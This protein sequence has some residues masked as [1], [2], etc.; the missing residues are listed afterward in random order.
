[1]NK[2]IVKILFFL[3]LSV[4]LISTA[5]AQRQT[6]S[7][8]GRATDNEG[9]PL[10]GATVILSGPAL[11]GT[12]SYVT[13]ETGD[14]RFP[15]VPPGR[16]YVITAEMPGF[17]K[18]I[19]TDLIVNVGKTFRVDVILVPEA[20]E[21]EITVTARAPTVDVTSSKE[22]V[23]YSSELIENI[24][25]ERS[26]Y[27]IVEAAPGVVG[28]GDTPSVHGGSGI[29]S[30]VSVD[31]VNITDRSMGIQTVDFSFDI[32]EEVELELGAHPAEVGLTESGY[33]NVVT[34]SGGNEFHGSAIAYYYNEDM[35]R[36]VIPE[37]EIKAVGLSEPTGPTSSHDFSL[38]F[39]GPIFKDKLWFFING[40]LSG[41]NY[42]NETIVDGVYDVKRPAQWGF[43]KL[44]FMAHQNIKLTGMASLK[45]YDSHL[46]LVSYY[47]GKYT[48]NYQDNIKN[49]I[50]LAMANWIVNQNTFLDFR[51]QFINI[52]RPRR[53]HPDSDP[54]E[55]V[56][57]DRYTGTRTGPARWNDN[58]HRY[59][60]A[61]SVSFNHFLDNVLGGNHQIKA[62]IEW[63]TS[64]VDNPFWDKRAISQLYT[65]Q[66]LPWGYHDV[67]PYKGYFVH[68]YIGENE[69]D[70]TL[71]SKVDKWG[72]Y[73]QDSFTIKNRLTL[74]FGL[75]YNDIRGHNPGTDLR[76][77][78]MNSP[79]LTMLAPELF[80]E[81]TVPDYNDIVV[82]KS[83]S[84]R[85]GV[86]YDLFG[87]QTTSIKASWSRYYTYLVLEL[88]ISM[89]N[90][91]PF[92]RSVNAFWFDLNKNGVI[93]TSDSFQ[94]VYKPPDPLQLDLDELVDPNLK[95][96]YTDEFIVGIERE[97]FKDF[98]FGVSYIYKEAYRAIEDVEKYRG[99]KPDSEWWIPY[100]T[101]EPGPDGVFGN[102]DDNQIT[103]YGVKEGAPRSRKWVVNL[104]DVKRKYQGLELILNKRMSHGWQLYGSVVISKLE[105]TRDV[106]Y[107]PS[108]G[109]TAPY[110]TPNFGINRY[111]RLGHDRPIVIKLQSSVILPFGFMVSGNYFYSSGEP[112]AR[113]LQIQL[114]ND[115]A[116]F[117]YPGNFTETVNAEIPGTR[118]YRSRNN[119]DL[120]I[121][122]QFRI[123]D[124]GRLGLFVDVLNVFGE[125]FFTIGEDPGGRVYNDGTFIR[126]SQYGRHNDIYGTRT[127]KASVR[128]TF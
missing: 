14:F 82:W 20:L 83:L 53:L 68:N 64:Y 88:F 41:E 80:K 15:A 113:T 101:T 78:G 117:E 21:E 106:G 128:F 31:G 23:T 86:V 59:Q 91:A 72:G 79:V 58:F 39:G 87:D 99:Y 62:G 76:P 108:L 124:F 13:T 61:A 12:L 123:R 89:G 127:F 18:F 66:G 47:R 42:R 30:T 63:E 40:R 121:E 71:L 116:T 95:S 125:N 69:D 54:L 16:D 11:M 56:K 33:I 43:G 107:G 109:H 81:V 49:W 119:L 96:P 93:E 57:I 105:G 92:G 60:Y 45:M 85:V 111:G 1:M 44:T 74:N 67:Q 77:V 100:T 55:P 28:D 112:W 122:K 38:T 97:L 4:G 51:F 5:F 27:S 24:P 103:V 84:P 110:D 114:P 19:R 25:V 9:A 6:G 8:A 7:I 70:W 52:L 17:K 26:Y 48:S 32:L 118:R 73:L 98:R 104:E 29:M 102:A 120:R 36:N 34:K 22:A 65:Y 94:V 126:Y 10:P 3:V 37:S 2:K 115:P 75:R 90:V 35:V 50:V 46:G